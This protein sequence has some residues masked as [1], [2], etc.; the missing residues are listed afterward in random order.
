MTVAPGWKPICRATGCVGAVTD[1]RRSPP[2]WIALALEPLASDAV[3][4]HNV[5]PISDVLIGWKVMP[6]SLQLA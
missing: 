6:A 2:G 5:A 3:S 4:I 1:L